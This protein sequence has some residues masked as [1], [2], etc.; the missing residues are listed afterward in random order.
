VQSP[1]PH[2]LSIVA[3]L[4]AIV[5]L[6]SGVLATTSATMVK[7]VTG[8][9]LISEQGHRTA[10]LHGGS[11][12]LVLL[13][14]IS[15]LEKRSWQRILGW[16]LCGA[17]IVQGLLGFSM[18]PA[19]AG[20][21]GVAHATLAQMIVAGLFVLVVGTS[22]AWNRE[23]QFVE[24]YG[25]P[26]LRSFR[27]S[28]PV[29]VLLQVMLGAMFRQQVTGLM[30]HILGAMFI[31][32]FILIAGSFVVHQCAEH[33]PLVP[34]AKTMMALTF[35]QIFLGI[36]DFTLRSMP[37]QATEGIL[38][39]TAAH[40]A[41]GALVLGISGVMGIAIGKHVLPKGSAAANT[42]EPKPA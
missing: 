32:L 8:N 41:N 16:V 22:E 39:I 30:L 19:P 9:S 27:R 3:I 33:K 2:R 13:I 28:L 36:A 15:F 17:T 10:G 35:V 24:D 34:I 20:W 4:N 26:S 25:W 29:L 5:V 42:V 23:P 7:P 1:W 31:S 14:A 40:I 38:G 18:P 12:L 11:V 6:V 21:H 37:T